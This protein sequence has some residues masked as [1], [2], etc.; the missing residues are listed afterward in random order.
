MSTSV[1][2]TLP[3]GPVQAYWNDVRLGSPKSTVNL[4][5]T[6]DTVEMRLEDAGLIVGSHKTGESLEVDV[7][8]ADLKPHQLRYVYDKANS[9][10]TAG[11]IDS[12]M[13]ESAGST[14]M[15]FREEI[16]LDGTTPVILR[17]AGF[18]TSSIKVFASDLSNTPDGYTKGTDFTA[19]ESTGSVTRIDGGSIG[20]GDSVVV[21]Y[22]HTATAEIVHAGGSLADFEAELKLVHETEDGKVL[23][24]KIH[25]AKKIGASEIAVQMATEFG[26]VPMTFRALADMSKAIGKQLMEVAVEA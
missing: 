24:F 13:Y 25:R 16:E 9:K 6:K 5:H 21:E 17:R 7:T 2:P 8:I 10:A 15:R 11:T 26:G 12:D 19:T 18:V 23:Q 1:A 20:D 22:N 3:I 4:R 14:I